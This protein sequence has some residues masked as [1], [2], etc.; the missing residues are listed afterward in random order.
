MPNVLDAAVGI[1]IVARAVLRF[2]APLR[3]DV[4]AGAVRAIVAA[5]DIDAPFVGRTE[6]DAVFAVPRA[7]VVA[8]DI[9]LGDVVRAVVCLDMRAVV[10]PV[11][12]G[13]DALVTGVVRDLEFVSRTA[14]SAGPATNKKVAISKNNL[15]I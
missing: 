13:C 5:R 14:A 7:F 2:D 9:V 11:V 12:R 1:D 6:I 4:C 8:R 10:F 3:R 15:L